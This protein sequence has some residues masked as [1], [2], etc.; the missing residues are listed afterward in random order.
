[1][2]NGC[3]VIKRSVHFFITAQKFRPLWTPSASRFLKLP[4]IPPVCAHFQTTFS[5]SIPA[6]YTELVLNFELPL[7]VPIEQ[8]ALVYALNVVTASQ[9]SNNC[10]DASI[11]LVEIIHCIECF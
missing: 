6:I 4:C 9:L 3:D 5:Q 7:G 2:D 8:Q 1:M 10:H 11:S